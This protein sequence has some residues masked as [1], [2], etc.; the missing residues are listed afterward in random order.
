MDPVPLLDALWRYPYG[1]SEQMT[2]VAMPLLYYNTLRS[3]A[4]R[5]VDPRIHNRVQD[6]V[7]TLLD[8]E[9]PD[10]AFGL[11]HAGDG[12]ATPW[13]GAYVTDFLYRA[14]QAGYAVPRAPME[15]AYGA[16]RRVARLNDFGSVGYQSEVYAW[17]GSND[18]KE[19]LR[20]RSA[21]YALYVLA[22]AGQA[23]I[24]QLRYFHDTRLNDEP[25]PLARAQIGAALAFMGDRVRSRHAFQMAESALGYRNIGD[26]YQTPLRDLSGVMALGGG[27]RRHRDGRSLAPA[28]R[29]RCAGCELR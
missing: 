21:A 13:L 11:W 3:E 24:G 5:S 6:S 8:R 22:R 7:T 28:A 19:L 29:T 14:Q 1:C 12:E 2:S 26:W 17:P 4:N 23:D 16:L 25:S 15:Q 9:G 18:T 10:G 20:S 27:S